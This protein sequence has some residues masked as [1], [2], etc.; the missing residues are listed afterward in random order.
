M[1]YRQILYSIGIAVIVSTLSAC[2][3]TTNVDYRAGY[4]F[5]AI[6]TLRLVSPA[7][8]GSGDTRINSPLVEERIRNAIRD[9]LVAKGFTV[10]DAAADANLTWQLGTRAGLESDRSGFSVGFGT[11]SR[12]SAVGIGYGFPGYD[13]DSYDESV[14]T[15]DILQPVD[16]SLLWR[17]S[18]SRRLVD[19][20]TPETITET[21]ND[22]VGRVLKKFPPTTR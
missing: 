8:P 5:S 15:I 21:I 16:N 18:D 17:G 10:I 14:L 7:E 20:A 6:R 2:A 11:F 1:K 12:H 13:V 19:G 4:D 22:L 9:Q 3:T